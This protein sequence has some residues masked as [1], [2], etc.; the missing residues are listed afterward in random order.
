MSY[1][2]KQPNPETFIAENEAFNAR[3]YA[4]LAEVP[5]YANVRLLAPGLIGKRVSYRL[6]WVIGASRIAH[7]RDSLL[8]P[9]ELKAWITERMRETYPDHESASGLTADEIK[10]LE[11]EQRQKRAKY[12]K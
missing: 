10:E 5:L 9:P 8:L 7:N 12:Q 2:I 4:E 6:G 11:A 3:L 1:H